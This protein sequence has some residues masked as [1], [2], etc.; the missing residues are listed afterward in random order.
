M[1]LIFTTICILDPSKT[2]DG[3]D[4]E[5]Q[6]LEYVYSNACKTCQKSNEVKDILDSPCCFGYWWIEND[7]DV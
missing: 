7:D 3:F 6:A 1:I 5:M 4:K 2:K